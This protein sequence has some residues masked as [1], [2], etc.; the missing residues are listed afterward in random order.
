MM[1]EVELTIRRVITAGGFGDYLLHNI[2]HGIGT[3]QEEDFPI[4][5]D[6]EIVLEP[7]MTFTVEPGIY[8]P[9]TGGCRIED[10]VVVTDTGCEVLS[11]LSQEQFID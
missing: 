5:P 11:G 4:G 10:V 6:C 9:G 2:G 3:D 1:K 8:M 7:G